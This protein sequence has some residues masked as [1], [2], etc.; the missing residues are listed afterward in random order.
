MAHAVL[1]PVPETDTSR[2]GVENKERIA[3][4]LTGVLADSYVLLFKTQGFHWNVVG[5]LFKPI[6]DLTEEHYKDLFDAVDDL[7]E[8]IRALGY[9][10]PQAFTDLVLHAEISEE[11]EARVPAAMVEQL[12]IDHETATRRMRDLAQLAAANKDGATEDLA[13]GRMA[14]H[15]EACWMLRAIIAE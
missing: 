2:S 8:R 5:P 4:A 9:L 3:N 12:I 14:F 11:T 10:A 6:H 15:E 1:T 7:A 13:N